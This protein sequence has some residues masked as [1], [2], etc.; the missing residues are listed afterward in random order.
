VVRGDALGEPV[1]IFAI[2]HLF[3]PLPI[4]GNDTNSKQLNWPRSQIQLMLEKALEWRFPDF[5]SYNK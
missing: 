1:L 4:T 5:R 3:N 2:P